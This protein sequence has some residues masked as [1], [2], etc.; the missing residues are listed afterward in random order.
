MRARVLVAAARYC[1]IFFFFFSAPFSK[2]SP[3]ERL[4]KNPVRV[5][6]RRRC[7]Q[8]VLCLDRVFSPS[9]HA[10]ALR[11]IFALSRT[12]PAGDGN[13]VDLCGADIIYIRGKTRGY[14]YGSYYI[15]I[16]TGIITRV[17]VFTHRYIYTHKS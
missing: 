8:P 5:G 15:N 4:A 7:L 9:D 2:S 14:G 10:H 13:R 11:R 1:L 12:L 6:I 16:S 3:P 17:T